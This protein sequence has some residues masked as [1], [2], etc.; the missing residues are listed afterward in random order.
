[1]AARFLLAVLV[2]LLVPGTLVLAQEKPA[3]EPTVQEALP[4]ETLQETI[5]GLEAEAPK[6]REAKPRPR[7]SPKAD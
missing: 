6:G 2:Y 4:T 7:S 3:P 1:M 5:R